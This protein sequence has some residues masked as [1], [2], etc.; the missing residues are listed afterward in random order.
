MLLR[1]P[2]SQH[3]QAYSYYTLVAGGA[4]PFGAH[5][6]D[7]G[8]GE[9]EDDDDDNDNDRGRRPQPCQ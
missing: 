5:D 8:G 1:S 9:D 7:I 4:D 2:P 6:C 3:W